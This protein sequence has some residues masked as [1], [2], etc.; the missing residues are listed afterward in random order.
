MTIG[1]T[2][3]LLRTYSV[4]AKTIYAKH[5]PLRKVSLIFFSVVVVLIGLIFVLSQ[6]LKKRGFV[7]VFVKVYNSYSDK[8]VLFQQIEKTN[9]A[10]GKVQPQEDVTDPISQEKISPAEFMTPHVIHLGNYACRVGLLLK[11]LFSQQL[12]NDQPLSQNT[13]TF[14]HPL[15]PGRF[16]NSEEHNALVNDLASFF[17]LS[18]KTFLSYWST[19]LNEVIHQSQNIQLVLPNRI[20]Y[21]DELM[22]AA[23]YISRIVKFKGDNEFVS[24][25]HPF[26]PLFSLSLDGQTVLSLNIR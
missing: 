5:T 26:Q 7:D 11:C 1:L 6:L 16:L 20:L 24:L 19:F 21:E 12:D 17:C 13:P 9:L 8:F 10:L 25:Q 22:K 23:R 3:V 14:K 2:V 15:E 4:Y 18:P